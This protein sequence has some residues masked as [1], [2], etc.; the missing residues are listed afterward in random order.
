MLAAIF[1][2]VGCGP[3][4][5]VEM[6]GTLDGG[7]TAGGTD[8]STT[9]T[10]TGLTTLP[11]P[12]STGGPLD[13]SGVDTSE[14]WLDL[15][16]DCSTFE[17]DCPPGFKCTF[18]DNSGGS[19]WNDTRCVPLEPDPA[20]EGEPCTVF[21]GPT[22]GLDD[23]DLT[24]MCWDVDPET[25]EGVC[26]PFCIG[27]ESNPT[28]A[29]RCAECALS[30]SILALCFAVCDPI[31]QNC[32][33]NQACYPVNDAFQCAPDASPRGTGIG[34]ECEYIN[35][36]PPGMFCIQSELVP[37]CDPATIGCCAPVCTSGGA[38]PCPGLLPGS[39]C[40]PWFREGGEPPDACVAGSPG[41]CAAP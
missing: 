31:V 15:P 35:V 23:C 41:I 29:S 36:C 34:S 3:T 11:P 14:V 38:D 30:S 9:G 28:C 39:V 1:V 13:S 40:Q 26:Q 5:D 22:S 7:T 12:S 18:W 19:S 16:E 4:I 24:T 27:D 8:R 2:L 21:D 33:S 10:T 32:P 6:T 20:A 25:N 37:G 17:Q